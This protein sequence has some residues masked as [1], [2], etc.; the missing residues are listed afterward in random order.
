MRDIHQPSFLKL[1]FYMVE[2]LIEKALSAPKH[3]FSYE[4]KMVLLLC[5]QSAKRLEIPSPFFFFFYT[6][7]G[8]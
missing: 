6:F 7:K 2:D 5:I 1:I 4:D 3:E 8:M